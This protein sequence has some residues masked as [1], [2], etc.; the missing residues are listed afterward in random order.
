MR[1][2]FL[3]YDF[4]EYSIR[5]ASALAQS[6]EVL[7]MLPETNSKPHLSLLDPKVHFRPFDKPRLR[8]PLRQLRTNYQLLRQIRAFQ[9]DVVHIQH[10]H[11]WSNFALPFLRTYPLVITIHDVQHHPGDKVSQKTPQQVLNY[12]FRSATQVI[13]HAEQLKREVLERLMLS[14]DNVC[15]IPHIAIGGETKQQ[16]EEDESLILFFGRIWPYKGLDYLIRAEPLITAEMP[17]VKIII[18]GEGENFSR[19]Q[20][21]MVHPERFIVLNEYVPED[22]ESELFQRASVV[23]L[24]YVEASQSGVIPVAYSYSKPVIATTVGGLPEM[25]DDGE[26]GFLVPPRD[27]RALA[28]AT[29]KL[30]KDK[31]LRH[32]MGAMGKRKLEAEC[33]AD[34]VAAQTLTVYRQA[35]ARRH[36]KTESL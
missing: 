1:V 3:S 7:L 35:V 36:L 31:A 24:P 32:K 10:G 29:V 18:A 4:G 25:V 19:Y 26:T 28:A 15:V 14:E 13:V 20:R 9:P 5:L 12:G 16:V 11:L 34:V 21:M 6:A 17:N 23:V 27:E 33:A 22:R 30:L 8:Q 2:A